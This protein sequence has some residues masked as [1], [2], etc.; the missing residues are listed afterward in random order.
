MGTIRKGHQV[1]PLA[2]LAQLGVAGD[3][4]FDL[5]FAAAR[6]AGARGEVPVGAAVSDSA[7]TILSVKGNR[8]RAAADAC[9]HAEL[10]A[11]RLAAARLRPG[12]SPG[13]LA[14][15]DLWVTL[16]P[17]A[18]CAAAAGLFR[19]RRILFSAYDPKGGGV[20]H[21][22][23]IFATSPHSHQPEIIGGIRESESRM[24]LRD[25]FQDVRAA[26]PEYDALHPAAITVV[27]R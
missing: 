23:R 18:M 21:G 19:I 1:S 6:R 17:C 9:A 24:M 4:P 14:D 10:L 8:M 16:E 27:Q 13:R 22:P 25:F 26:C 12:A 20:E 5:A 2:A 15:C 3:R 11:M 7:G